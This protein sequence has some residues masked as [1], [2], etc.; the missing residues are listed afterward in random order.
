MSYFPQSLKQKEN[1]CFRSIENR[2]E[3]FDDLP[4][5]Q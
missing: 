4:A 3:G 1:E 5:V 2:N